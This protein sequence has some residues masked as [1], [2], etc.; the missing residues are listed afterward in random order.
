MMGSAKAHYECIKA[1]SET[2]FTEDLKAIEVPVLV[3]HSEDDQIVPYADSAPLAV[4]LLQNGTLKTYKDLP[5][6]LCQTHPELVNPEILA[7][8]RG[9]GV[10]EDQLVATIIPAMA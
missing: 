2:D 10:Q 5:H 3:I 4:A 6:G 8:I 9:V 7:F 1:F